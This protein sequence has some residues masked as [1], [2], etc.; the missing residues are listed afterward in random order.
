[1]NSRNLFYAGMDARLEQQILVILHV[2][3]QGFKDIANN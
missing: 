2:I 1:M 3:G